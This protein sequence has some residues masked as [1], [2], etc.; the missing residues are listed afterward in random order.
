[1]ARLVLAGQPGS[2]GAGTGR[3]LF[4]P[5]VAPEG[6]TVESPNGHANPV[7]EE[8]RLAEALAAAANE[9]EELARTTSERA[10][11]EVGAIFEAQ[12]L[13]ARDPG[14]V[15]PAL[16]LVRSGTSAEKA[17]D[18]ASGQ[19]ADGLAAVDDEYFRERAADLRDVGRRVVGLLSGRHRPQ[20]YLSNGSMAI[21]AATD[22][23]PSIVAV[24]RPELVAGIVLSAGAPNGHAAI[25]AR[26]LGMPLVLGLGAQLDPSLD[27]ARAA[28]DGATGRLVVEPDARDIDNAAPRRA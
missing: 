11:T 1:M 19:A 4:V 2:P 21:L 28:L 20:L 8:A 3:L 23:D 12:A 27:G 15:G 24:L 13:F 25:V 10:G 6:A 9:L 14:V 17:M 22:L 26:A 18:R 5:T 16:D 7:S